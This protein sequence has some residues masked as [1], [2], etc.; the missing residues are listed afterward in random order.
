MF[1]FPY[2]LTAEREERKSKRTHCAGIATRSGAPET[3]PSTLT[4]IGG[5]G[6]SSCRYW[7]PD[8]TKVE[9]LAKYRMDLIS[10]SLVQLKAESS[11]ASQDASL[12]MVVSSTTDRAPGRVRFSAS[13]LARCAS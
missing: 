5:G 13:R 3:D 11:T 8:P 4:V 9:H 10:R 2:G 6:K 1:M 12:S 7:L